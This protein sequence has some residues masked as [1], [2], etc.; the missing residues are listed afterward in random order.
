ML[1]ETGDV[2]VMI[3]IRSNFYYSRTVPCELWF[4][5][6]GKPTGRRD[7]V[8]MIDGRNVF[9]K[10]NRTI[11]DFSPEQLANLRAIVLLYRGQKDRFLKLVRNYLVATVA[12]TEK[13]G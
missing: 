12:E 8:L 11:N 9:R 4:V 2:D 6:R 3:S 1:L 10:V 5:D 13:L 7:Q